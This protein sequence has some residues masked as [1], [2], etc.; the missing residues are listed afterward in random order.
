MLQRCLDLAATAAAWKP[1]GGVPLLRTLVGGRRPQER[2]HA[3]FA[4]VDRFAPGAARAI[5]R[6]VTDPRALAMQVGAFDL[7]GFGG[8]ASVFRCETPAGA[9]VLKIFRR[10]LGRPLAEQREV[11]AY[12]ADRYRTVSG[13]YASL[14]GLVVPTAFVI[15]PGPFLGRAVAAAVQ[16][17]VEPRICFFADQDDATALARLRSDRALA[18]RFEAFG[19]RTLEIYAKE[20]RCL[21]L[22]GR[23]NLML[24]DVTGRARLAV[25]DC[26]ILEVARLEIETPER[27]RRLAE[28]IARLESILT[29]LR[30]A[31]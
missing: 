25:A 23:E 22:V 20:G 7:I 11:A 27:A 10:S 24:V 19:A 14:P 16:P 5:S 26:G 4:L 21:D 29:G 9:R 12:Y 2:I 1:H 15:L 3:G 31:R 17:L 18:Q 6:R 28:R 8:G 30:A 13:W